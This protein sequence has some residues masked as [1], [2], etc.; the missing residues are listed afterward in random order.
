MQENK[1]MLK[2]VSMLVLG[3]PADIGYR[4]LQ[5]KNIIDNRNIKNIA[6]RHGMK[7]D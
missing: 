3:V 1:K 2:C 6:E 7:H 4:G 5:G